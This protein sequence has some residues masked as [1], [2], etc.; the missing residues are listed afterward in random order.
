MIYRGLSIFMRPLL[1]TYI[2]AGIRFENSLL[3]QYGFAD[4]DRKY[5]D[6]DNLRQK[7]ADVTFWTHRLLE[8]TS[9]GYRAKVAKL[10]VSHLEDLAS[11]LDIIAP[12]IRILLTPHFLDLIIKADDEMCGSFELELAHGLCKDAD[13]LDSFDTDRDEYSDLYRILDSRKNTTWLPGKKHGT[14]KAGLMESRSFFEQVYPWRDKRLLLFPRLDHD[15]SVMS[16]PLPS[17]SSGTDE[18]RLAA[19]TPKLTSPHISLDSLSASAD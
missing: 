8:D 2:E 17:Q 6:Y 13:V 19:G 14:L 3:R 9:R 7:D 4:D 15:E 1:E 10:E 18:A 16:D 5:M 12:A 11:L